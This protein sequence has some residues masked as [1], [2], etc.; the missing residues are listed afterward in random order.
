MKPATQSLK[1][2]PNPWFMG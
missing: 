1:Y 2:Y